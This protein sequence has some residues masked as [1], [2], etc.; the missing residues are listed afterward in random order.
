MLTGSYWFQCNLMKAGCRRVRISERGNDAG[1]GKGRS[2]ILN[3]P[4][5]KPASSASR[6]GLWRTIAACIPVVAVLLGMGVQAHAQ[7]LP[8][9]LKH[10]YRNQPVLD[11]ARAEQRITDELKPQA[12]SGWRPTVIA[13]ANIGHESTNEDLLR[14]DHTD[15]MGLS[16]RLT[17]PVFRGFRTVSATR[18]AD[19]LIAAGRQQLIDV[20]Q[21]ILLDAIKAYMDVIRDREVLRLRRNQVALLSH[22][23]RGNRRRLELGMVTRTD[24]AQ[25]RARL[26][27]AVSNVAGAEADLGVSVNRYIRHVGRKPGVLR[28]PPVSRR[29]PKSLDRAIKLA[30]QYNPEILKA[31]H[32]EVAARHFVDVKR[33]ELLPQIGLEAEY[34]HNSD[35][36]A[37]F[38]EDETAV[39]RGVVTV[40]IYQAG[41]SYSQLRQAKQ[42][43]NRRRMLILAARRKI[44]GQV[45]RVWSRYRETE[46]KISAVMQQIGAA[47][48]AVEGVRREALNGSRTTQEVLDAE[49]ELMN[50][51]IGLEVIRR[52]RIV[53]AYE[54]IKTTGRLTAYNLGLAVAHYDPHEYHDRVRDR[55]F[56]A[57]I[58]H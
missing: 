15:P 30:D 32:K 56:G 21:T 27:S 14:F 9:A 40:P 8:E 22:E 36:R 51:R 47:M 43:V 33:G 24:V 20:E 44:R 57:D 58:Q 49:R 5:G 29:I 34:R 13:Q 53:R 50:T 55:W 48:V 7:S 28:R 11:A 2:G 25:A 52:D 37:E 23:L 54:V 4:G 6:R 41:S 3:K 35:L 17:Q 10:A 46:G 45:G 42:Q 38:G 18:Q 31:M 16:I 19:Q 12:L 39:F 1:V 26:S